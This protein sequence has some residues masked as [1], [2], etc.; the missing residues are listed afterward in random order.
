LLVQPNAKEKPAILLLK[1][2]L[3]SLVWFDVDRDECIRRAL[4]RRYD[5][6][7]DNIYHIQDSAPLT[8]NAP[9]IER[10]KNMDEE[11]N[12]EGTLIDRWIAFDNTS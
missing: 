9:L 5:Q 1:S 11:N 4:G 10:L 2:G 6:V 12:T 7:N 8:T 3:D